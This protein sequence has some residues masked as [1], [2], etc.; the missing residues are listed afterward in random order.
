MTWGQ[1][2]G[3]SLST[4]TSTGSIVHSQC[5]SDSVRTPTL[6]RPRALENEELYFSIGCT[7][8]EPKVIDAWPTNF[9]ADMMWVFLGLLAADIPDTVCPSPTWTAEPPPFVAAGP[10]PS[11]SRALSFCKRRLKPQLTCLVCWSYVTSS[12]WPGWWPTPIDLIQSYCWELI[13]V[14]SEATDC[15]LGTYSSIPRKSSDFSIRHHI[16]TCS[17]SHPSSFLMDTVRL[18]MK[19]PSPPSR[20]EV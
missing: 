16:H 6:A 2:I 4:Q 20:P 10:H 19:R 12:C 7:H 5:C 11:C 13:G 14:V 1:F 8:A 3:P 17:G 9:G 18:S 15:G